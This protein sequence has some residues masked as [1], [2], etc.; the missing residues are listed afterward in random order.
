MKLGTTDILTGYTGNTEW[1]KVMLG[2]SQIWVK[3]SGPDYT[4]PFYVEDVSGSSNTLTIKKS[5][6][7]APTLTVE[8]SSDGVNWTSMG[9]TSTT[10]ITATVPAN[11]RLYLRCSINHW[12]TSS[13][14]SN[15]INMSKNYKVGGNSMSLLYGSNFTGNERTLPYVGSYSGSHFCRLFSGSSTLQDAQDLLLP[16]ETLDYY[17]YAYM[18]YQCYSLKTAPKIMATSLNSQATAA[19]SYMFYQCRNIVL[20][21]KINISSV[22][23]AIFESMFQGCTSLSTPLELLATTLVGKCYKNLFSG[24]TS[25]NYIKCL[26]TDI[27]A[28]DC[29][30][31]WL[32]GVAATGTI[33]TPSSTS[34][35][36]GT[37]GIPSG[38]TRVDA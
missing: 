18:F 4:I 12:A 3:E 32:N 15:R 5:S 13:D 24:C 11:G 31:N 29:T 2:T 25:L 20:A 22:T 8:K 28:S 38:W 35:T 6:S 26:A 19:M 34:W 21:P 23:W 27:S 14:Y 36:T 9:S 37:S 17:S 30:N 1:S 33:I 10:G 7:S 16:S